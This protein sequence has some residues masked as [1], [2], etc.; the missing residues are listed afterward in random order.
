MAKPI[1]TLELHYQMIQFLIN[2]SILKN[3]KIA[4]LGNC[5]LLFY[6]Q[7]KHQRTKQKPCYRHYEVV[8]SV[9]KNP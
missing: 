3:R 2:L 1:K 5:N 6:Q 9:V 7:A 8:T 4:K